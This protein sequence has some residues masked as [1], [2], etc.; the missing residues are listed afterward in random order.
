MVSVWTKPNPLKGNHNRLIMAFA[1]LVNML[2]IRITSPNKKTNGVHNIRISDKTCVVKTRSL[3]TAIECIRT[4][5]TEIGQSTGR[6]CFE[7][8]K[9]KKCVRRKYNTYDGKR[10]HCPKFRKRLGAPCSYSGT[11]SE[12]ISFQ[13]F[14][15]FLH[16]LICF[17]WLEQAFSCIVAIHAMAV[18]VHCFKTSLCFRDSEFLNLFRLFDNEGRY[19]DRK[20]NYWSGKGV[21]IPF[22][23]SQAFE[24]GYIRVRA[25]GSLFL[26]W[27]RSIRLCKVGG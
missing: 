7:L 25:S 17:T 20:L 23:L 11:G 26:F 1:T 16:E 2:S 10:G 4:T 19:F 15:L 14:V 24:D 3:E 5:I 22:I 18:W 12:V 21:E 27:V 13:V 8:C 6:Q 9:T